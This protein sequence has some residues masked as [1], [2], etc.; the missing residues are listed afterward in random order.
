MANVLSV[1]I[2]LL[3]KLAAIFFVRN[4]F[5]LFCSVAVDQ[6]QKTSRHFSTKSFE[7]AGCLSEDDRSDQDVMPPRTLAF[8]QIGFVFIYISIYAD[9]GNFR[10]SIGACLNDL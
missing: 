2:I 9:M 7:R 4:F 6:M 1:T 5:L 3:M 10:P 8:V